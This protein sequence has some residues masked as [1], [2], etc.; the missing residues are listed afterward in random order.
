MFITMSTLSPV[1]T[2]FNDSDIFRL[3]NIRTLELLNKGRV[4]A[5]QKK[6]NLI[7][8]NLRFKSHSFKTDILEQPVVT[9]IAQSC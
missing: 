1:N 5:G 4:S 2:S 7:Q 3:G 9:T 6:I 8:K